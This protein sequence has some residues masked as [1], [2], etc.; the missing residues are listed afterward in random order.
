MTGRARSLIDSYRAQGNLIDRA[1]SAA[2]QLLNPPPDLPAPTPQ[3][4]ADDQL[5][6]AC[7]TIARRDADLIDTILTRLE[8]LAAAERDPDRI[9]TLYG[10]DHLAT[11][12]RRNTEALRVLAG[13]NAG[14]VHHEATPLLDTIRAAL[15]AIEHYPRVSIGRV[16]ALA[17]VGSAADDVSRLLA[18]LLDNA[19]GQ[20][21]PK[22]TVLVSAHLTEKGSVLVRVEDEGVGLSDPELAALNNR[23][24]TTERT[25]GGLGLAVVRRLAGRHG[26]QVWLGR[27]APHGTTA[28]VLL[29][30][31]LVR[32]SPAPAEPEP[33]P[34]TAGGLPR[35][36]PRKRR[37][38][39]L[40]VVEAMPDRGEFVA[41]LTAFAEGHRAA[42]T[43]GDDV[44]GE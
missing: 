14:E 44:G 7:T 20:S 22:T 37:T 35:R 16:A 36:I 9:A 8:Q 21:P 6:N 1:R 43:E 28:S 23:L 31:D 39:E 18:E 41:D 33:A 25:G 4:T 30:S 11:R 12:L 42:Q 26:I 5:S 19:T 13:D 38:P 24:S 40:S 15:S 27:R 32:E 17:V 29:P 10:L 2:A 3:T 34:R